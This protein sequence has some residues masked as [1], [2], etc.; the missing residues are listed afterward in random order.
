MPSELRLVIQTRVRGMWRVR[1]LVRAL[2]VI[3]RVANWLLARFFIVE[4]RVGRT[5]KWEQLRDW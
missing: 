3:E 5:G 1:A 2:K 4:F